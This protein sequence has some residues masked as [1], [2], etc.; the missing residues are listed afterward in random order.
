M[1]GSAASADGDR[2]PA[3]VSGRTVVVSTKPLEPFVFIDG[4]GTSGDPVDAA[5][6]RGY[7][8]DVW[9]DIATR[10]GLTTTWV[11]RAKVGEILDDVSSGDSDVAIA[12]ISMTPEREQVI[13]F[14]HPYFDAGLQIVT[15][16]SD[17]TSVLHTVWN[18][19]TSP[20]IVLTLVFLV[21]MLA[22]V[23]HLIWWHERSHNPEFP[24]DYRSGIVE[25]LWWATVNVV[26]GGEAVKE[27]RRPF[28]RLL[29]IGW[30]VV[31]L[32]VLT[33]VTAQAASALTVRQLE[34]SITG[35]DDLPGNRV[36]TVGDT[37][38]AQYLDDSNLTYTSF[39]DVDSALAALAAGDVDAVVYDAPVLQYRAGTDYRNQIELAGAA[40]DPDPYAIALQPGS[41]LREPIDEAIL[42]M[43]QDGTLDTLRGKWFRSS[44]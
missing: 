18:L 40:F 28:S 32:F 9:N 24:S 13:D 36:G 20:G 43:R 3:D 1:A 22:L 10:L 34:S 15:T 21:V 14:S 23:S 41:D 7:S 11:Q 44:T 42:A 2:R 17:T 39:A 37:V 33:F 4:D 26:T 38:A 5:A 8:I 6:L 27:I 25:A 35:V 16:G 12:G 31:G 29:A 30:M 19:V